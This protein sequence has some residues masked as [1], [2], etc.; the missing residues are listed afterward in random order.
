[1][2]KSL[3]FFQF[4]QSFNAVRYE[5]VKLNTFQDSNKRKSQIV[6]ENFWNVSTNRS[7]IIILVKVLYWDVLTEMHR[8]YV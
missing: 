7:K 6:K 1:M 8:N 3:L 5:K 4:A 2:V